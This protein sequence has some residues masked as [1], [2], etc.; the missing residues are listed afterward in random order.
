[1][2]EI[3]KYIEEYQ[4]FIRKFTTC[5]LLEYFSN[6][7]IQSYQSDKKGVTIV[8]VPYYNRRTGEKGITKGFCYGQWELVQICYN[9]I[10]YSND[11]RGKKVDESS[12]YHLI[13]EN[14]K[15]DEKLKMETIQNVDK[16]G[17]F[18]HLQFLGN[19]QFDFQTLN[20][21]SRFDRMYQI[22]VNINRNKDYCQTREV[23]YINFAE[24]FEEITNIEY[25]KFI[26]VYFFLI[27]FSSGRKNTNIY[28]FIDDIK[29]DVEKIGFTKE[30]IIKVIDLQS[31]DYKFYRQ[32]NNWNLLRFYPIVKT[33]KD[34]NKYI[35]S[36]IYSLML[37]FPDATY[38]II[39]N[40]YNEI[41]SNDFT[42]YFGKCFEYYLHEILEYYDIKYEKLKES[43]IQNVKM[44]DWKI[45]TQ[46]YVFLIEQKSAL[47][48]IDTRTTTKNESYDKIEEYFE[49]N[50]IKAFKQLNS[51][52]IEE[53]NKTVIRI[54]LTFEKIYMEENVKYIIA[55]KMK[56]DS[57]IT[58][59]WIVNIDEFEILM[60]I[61]NEDEENFNKI[62]K[63]KIEL[64]VTE[65]KDGRNL[66][67]LLGG[68]KYNYCTNV[69]KHFEEIGEFLKQKIEKLNED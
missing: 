3:V 32:S 6:I 8:N 49:K 37:S 65:A 25:D 35:I 43:T 54:C 7:S 66:E 36:N 53:N 14:K 26:Y 50:F 47:F 42:V 59:N 34:E 48:P 39:R 41:K 45:E 13:N 40:Y 68:R 19:I 63:E 31:R 61:L 64:E 2:D 62:I 28:D 23:C 51:Y 46:N 16:I 30:D 29:F 58:L 9:S 18:E 1:M 15:Y 60:E 52:K 55:K 27:L 22:M 21:V 20:V 67:K 12:F 69:L 17:L 38:W 24:K 11:Y 4:K 5:D 44:P 10:K 33:D 56:F 57:D